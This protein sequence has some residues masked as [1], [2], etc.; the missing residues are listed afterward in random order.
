MYV[1][2]RLRQHVLD[3]LVSH[4]GSRQTADSQTLL[5]ALSG[6]VDSMVLLDLLV[7][8]QAQPQVRFI[9]HALHVH[10]GISPNA[11]TWADVCS[12]CCDA[13]NVPMQ[14]TRIQLPADNDS[15]IEAAARQARYHALSSQDANHVLLAHH[16]DD[17]AETL[18]LQLLRGSGVKGLAAM[19]RHDAERKL[20]RP[21]L[22]VARAD[23]LEYAEARKL[24]WVEDESNSDTHFDRNFC[25]HQVLPVLEQRF[26]AAKASFARSA[27]HMA[28]AASLLDELAAI[29][30][31]R[32]AIG[33]Q[34]D[35]A[36]LTTLSMPRARNLF[37][38]WLSQQGYAMPSTAK[39]DDM[40]SQLMGARPDAMLKVAVD[41][42]R[43]I[44]LRRY[45]GMGYLEEDRPAPFSMTW[46]GEAELMLSYNSRLVFEKKMGE[47]L[48][49]SRL[50]I[51]KLRISPRIGG[52]RF[53]PDMARPTRTLKHLL[54]EANMPPWQRQQLPLV[55]CDDA[56]AVV[57][58][59]GVASHMQAQAHEE[60]LVIR[61]EY[62]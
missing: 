47:G 27:S 36:A 15:G 28:E 8:A 9:L 42:K 57:P 12:A 54:Q 10:H 61:W 56:L 5:L 25:R 44:W 26:P 35:L 3:F 18:L 7:Y 6:G 34:L 16:Q 29:D 41:S 4:F 46:Q 62:E 32:C 55:Y 43:G 51:D 48:A 11:D 50:C 2:D 38:W 40:L 22:D 45:N 60:G 13:L 33:L 31:Q 21:L 59:I 53:K 14:V 30:G 24:Q 52:E 17:Q 39:L 20:L 1:V 58:A 23:I 37:R 49:Y 19:G